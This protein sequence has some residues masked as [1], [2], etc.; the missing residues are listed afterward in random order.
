M[1]ATDFDYYRPNTIKEALGLFHTLSENKKSPLYFNGGTEFITFRRIETLYTEVKAVI[2][3]KNINMCHEI[4]EENDTFIIGASI[5]L[6]TIETIPH[7]PL[8]SKV[9]NRIADH[10]SR[11]K[12]T[13]GGNSCSNLKYKEAILPLLLTNCDV[14][15]ASP[16]GLHTVPIQQIYNIQTGKIMLEHGAF[17]VQFKI[18]K[19]FLNMPFTSKKVTANG[20]IGYPL[21]TIS[22]IHM[23]HIVRFAF[24]G[25]C[26]APFQLDMIDTT[27][28]ER[29]EPLKNRI[30]KT[31]EQLPSPILD[32]MNGSSEFRTFI[33]HGLVKEIISEFGKE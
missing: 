32:D 20:R 4:K 22:A 6:A 13:L 14:V 11:E 30:Q 3:I 12:I 15:I 2:D 28:N 27:L 1:I 25:L 33:F 5:P 31:L 19:V 8:L 23:P 26:H 7:F 21:V 10:T 9:C 17:I 24:S 16:T 18:D 29:N